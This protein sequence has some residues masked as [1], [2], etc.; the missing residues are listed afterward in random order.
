MD[1]IEIKSA[2]IEIIK[3]MKE[4]SEFDES[5]KLIEGGLID[6]FDVMNL[7]TKLQNKFNVSVDGEDLTSENFMKVDDIAELILRKLV[8]NG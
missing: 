4:L 8:N 7:V 3:R 2:I 1:L 6:S 5:I